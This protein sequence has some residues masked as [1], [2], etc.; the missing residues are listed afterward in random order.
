MLDSRLFR[1]AAVAA[2]GLTAA[3][4]L[5]TKAAVDFESSMADVR[6]VVD[7]LES[8]KAFAQIN[9]E[10]LDLSGNMPIAAKGFAEIYAAAG[11]AGIAREDLKQFAEQVAQVSIA[12]DMTAEEAGTA[13]AKIMT[14]L[15]LSIP[16]MTNLGD[17]MNHLS[18]NSASTAAQLVDF[19]LR[20]GQAGQSAGLTA[21]QTAAF[22]SA[23]IA[24]GAQ[25][26]VAAT[27]FRNMIKALSR[28]PSMTD[29]QI[30]ALDRL[31]FAQS[32]A[33]TN[34]K[35]Y[36]DAVRT[37]SETRI[38]IA[39][40]ETDQ[41]AKELNR[42]FRDQMT[43]IR[44]G[45]DDE[46]EAFTERLQDQAEAQIQALQRRQRAE[47]DAARDRAEANGRS[48]QQEIY[49][50]QDAFDQRIDAVRDKLGDELKERRRADRDRLTAIQDDMNDRK[51]LELA[52]LESNF[53]EIKDREKALMAERLADIEAQAA[54]GAIAA[55][56]ALAKGLQED[57][58]GTITDVFDRIRELPKEAQLSVVSDLFGDEA[59][60]ILP[61][62]NNTELLEKSMGLVG[63]QT[64]YAGS[65]LNEF[66]TRVST[67][68]NQ[69]Q[70]AQN[71]IQN[72]SIVFGQTFAPALGALLTALSPVLESFTWLLQNVP[73]LAPVIAVLTTAFIALVAVL[74]ALGGLV[75][76]LGAI[77]GGAGAMAGLATAVGLVKAA[78]LAVGAVLTGP[79]GLAIL[80]AGIVTAA[81]SFR[82][83]IGLVLS[84]V[85]EAFSTVF[86]GIFDFASGVFQQLFDFY[87][88]TFIQP[89]IEIAQGLHDSFVDIFTRIGEAIQAPFVA[90]LDAVKSVLNS[91]VQG[92]ARGINS[93]ILMIN[94]VISGANRLPNV[95]IPLIPQIEIP[96]FAEGG[97]VTGPTLGLV[98]EAG[99][100]YIVPAR[101]AQGFAQNI[102]AGVRG[103]GA[104]PRFA[105]GGYVAPASVNIQTGPV[106]QMDG[107]NFVTTQDLSRA[108]QSGV[109]QTLD[110]IRRDSSIRTSLGMA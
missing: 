103:P 48:A 58:I 7:G 86:Q 33:V 11:Q 6:K 85:G 12:F 20:A 44:D 18:N 10:I 53:N 100:E 61:L 80:L 90:A 31:G 68:A 89:V 36:S 17:A 38:N 8:P 37:E 54:A 71:Q 101:K 104:I 91:I 35:V 107:T 16:E 87:N 105:E 69:V 3:I 29:R 109:N 78:F 75:T 98:G 41:L 70:Q 88:N 25:A 63:D 76:V 96:A 45:L 83:Q 4:A 93:A 27:S 97:M 46:T 102:L 108:V 84:A 22:G 21:E 66:L 73:G 74:P 60:A 28:G 110:L 19:T 55:A 23:M 81:Y 49:A 57:A 95:N 72:L 5:S 34:E 24:S 92:I 56:E 94:R 79:V 50:I 51:E 15:G 52:G 59:R 1:T 42:R 67:T 99:P 77:G 64:Q 2:A 30:G 13:M 82:E 32:D 40:N 9:Q 65:T 14:S 106:T 26:D 47:I 62:I 39:R 43:I